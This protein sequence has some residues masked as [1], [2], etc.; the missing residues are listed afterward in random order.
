MAPGPLSPVLPV[1]VA[2]NVA[3][4]TMIYDF[5]RNDDEHREIR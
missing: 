2:V 4:E 1:V 5:N 3:V